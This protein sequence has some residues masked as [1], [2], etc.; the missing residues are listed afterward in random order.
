MLSRLDESVRHPFLEMLSCV[1]L[2]PVMPVKAAGILVEPPVCV[3]IVISDIFQLLY[4]MFPTYYNRY[5][6]IV[7]S[8]ILQLFT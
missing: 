7:I 2:Y 3:P 6:K 5:F 8:Y 4:Q 1:G